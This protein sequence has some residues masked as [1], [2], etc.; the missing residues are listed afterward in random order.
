MFPVEVQWYLGPNTDTS[1]GDYGS[2]EA[3]MVALPYNPPELNLYKFTKNHIIEFLDIKK[4]GKEN[5]S[6]SINSLSQIVGRS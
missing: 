4:S 1:S 2:T 6:D 5:S 3:P